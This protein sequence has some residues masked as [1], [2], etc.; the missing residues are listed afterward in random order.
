M[1]EDTGERLIPALHK[2]SLTYGEHL[3]RYM[4]VAKLVKGKK[5]LDIACGVGYGSQFIAKTAKEVWGADRSKDAVAYAKKNYKAPNLNFKVTDALKMDFKDA[6][7]DVVVSLET[8][9]HLP[10][11]AKFVA[12]V[13]RVLK[14]GG[15]FVVS[16]P[17]DNEFTEGNVYHVHEFDLAEMEKVVGGAFKNYKLYFQ[18]TWFAA[19]IL[20][21][22]TF[23]KGGDMQAA[24]VQMHPQPKEKAIYYI[25][26]CSDSRLP[27]LEQSVAL[28]DHWSSKDDLERHEARVKHIE[29]LEK[30][31]INLSKH[32]EDLKKRNQHMAEFYRNP[33]VGGAKRIARQ[34]RRLRKKQ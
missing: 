19:A 1:I 21:Q 27:E 10:E 33:V 9:E 15:V 18:G 16:T 22:K 34:I 8:I 12:E 6:T 26:V 13:R 31:L 3:S 20:D 4:T 28:A 5:V 24:V 14:P 25:A 7:F 2:H 23:E 29:G 17:N 30:E 32:A 11:P